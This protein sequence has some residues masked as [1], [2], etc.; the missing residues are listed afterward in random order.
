MYFMFFLLFF[1][2]ANS[3]TPKVLNFDLYQTLKLFELQG[4]HK[5]YGKLDSLNLATLQHILR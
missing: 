2:H 3:K 4:T 1:G 5:L